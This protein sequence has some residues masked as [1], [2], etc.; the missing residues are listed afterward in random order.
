MRPQTVFTLAIAA[1][2]AT[3]CE[4]AVAPTVGSLGGRAAST[5]STLAISPSTVTVTVGT[6]VQLSTNAPLAVQNQVEWSSSNTTVATISPTGLLNTFAAGS[7]VV[8][9]RLA[10]DTTQAA[11]AAITVIS[12]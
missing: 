6:S 5:S 9:A 12:P 1:C 2:L 7:S 10:S 4:Q 8:T 3:G 11:T